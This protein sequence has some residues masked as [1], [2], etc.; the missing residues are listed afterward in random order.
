MRLL[1]VCW[2]KSSKM[3]LFSYF[4]LFPH[5]KGNRKTL[6]KNWENKIEHHINSS[7]CESGTTTT[8]ER[9]LDPG[10]WQ[11]VWIFILNFPVFSDRKISISLAEFLGWKVQ[12][13]IQHEIDFFY[14]NP[15]HIKTW[16]GYC[17]VLRKMYGHHRIFFFENRQAG[18][19]YT[20]SMM[21]GCTYETSS[22]YGENPFALLSEQETAKS[23]K[24]QSRKER[25]PYQLFTFASFLFLTSKS[26]HFIVYEYDLSFAAFHSSWHGA[27][28]VCSSYLSAPL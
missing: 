6:A 4:K 18:L 22:C 11:A 7:S 2:H 15:L 28:M 9:L 25:G 20:A 10:D 12:K 5:A 23:F 26:Q 17:P 16:F 19:F 24:A 21:V 8:W 13:I 1:F 27:K 14:K 3:C